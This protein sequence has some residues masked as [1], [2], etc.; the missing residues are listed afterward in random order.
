MKLLMFLLWPLLLANIVLWAA[1]GH[2]LMTT[3]WA[4]L[5]ISSP[6]LLPN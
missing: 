1:S 4:I 6:R 5:L 3:V 2:V